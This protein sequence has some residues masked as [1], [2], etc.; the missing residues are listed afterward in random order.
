MLEPSWYVVATKPRQELVALENLER[1]GYRVQLPKVELRKRR[2]GKWQEVIEPLFPGY[3]FV[4]LAA[5]VDDTAPIRS[6]A[7]CVGLVRFGGRQVPVPDEFIRPFLTTGAR[8]SGE[9]EIVKS[10][11]QIRLERG[12]FA[13][14]LAVFDLPKGEDRAQILLEILGKARQV[15]VSVVTCPAYLASAT[16]LKP[17]SWFCSF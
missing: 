5:G 4:A 11:E 17:Y 6:T 3:L 2:R 7:G 9:H 12:P 16:S 1:Q 10:G 8:T 15:T 14:L 13:G